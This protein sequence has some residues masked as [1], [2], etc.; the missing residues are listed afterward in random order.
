MGWAF[1]R[2]RDAEFGSR[3]R[4]RAPCGVVSRGTC[5]PWRHQDHQARR[6]GRAVDR[7]NRTRAA[8]ALL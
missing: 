5:H 2:K 4:A 8:S 3:R 1:D 6:R 7:W